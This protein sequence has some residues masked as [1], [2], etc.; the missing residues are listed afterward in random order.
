[1]YTVTP[2]GYCIN[3]TFLLTTTPQSGYINLACTKGAAMR[4]DDTA[5]YSLVD[6]PGEYDIHGH[7]IVCFDAW[8]YLHYHIS[9]DSGVVVIIQDNALL[10]KETLGEV[11][12]W[13]CTHQK[14]KDAIERDE[15]EGSI[16]VMEW[17]TYEPTE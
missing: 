12:T 14:V 4:Y 8:W 15:L 11:T 7:A 5:R 13:L 2:H 9:T 17:F 3:D 16:V 10:E 1:M 6:F